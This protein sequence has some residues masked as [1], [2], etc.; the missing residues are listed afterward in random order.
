M[1]RRRQKRKGGFLLGTVVGVAAGF[2]GGTALLRRAATS[3]ETIEVI[4]EQ[5]DGAATAFV[6]TVRE[7]PATVTDQ[8]QAI[9]DSIKA[10]WN[11][12][13]AEGKVAAAEKE[14]ELQARLAFETKRVP[15]ME[16]EL[17][18]R[19]EQRLQRNDE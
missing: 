19:V 7:T 10:R 13:V 17:I 18:E 8:V 5:P 1:V 14:R 6:E 11:A 3:E 9:V 2:A 15:P 4:G 12:A 16:G